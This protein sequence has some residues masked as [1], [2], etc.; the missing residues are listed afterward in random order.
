MNRARYA[1]LALAACCIIAL[2]FDLTRP[3]RVL[4]IGDSI[5]GQYAPAAAATLRNHG[6]EAIVRSY[7]GVGLLDEGPRIDAAVEVRHDIASA[8]ARVV[9]A[10]F[11][12]NYG[13]VDPPLPGVP[14]GSD[15]F[16]AAW[17]AE[18]AMLARQAT[19]AG[20]SLV[21]LLAPP[22][23]RGDTNVSTRLS[24]LY[25]A[26]QRGRVT[27][28]DPATAISLLDR[29]GGLYAPDGRH[30]S[31]SG[32]KVIAN[33]VTERVESHSRLGLRFDE[34]LHS[35]LVIALAVIAAVAL[36]AV[37]A[38]RTPGGQRRRRLRSLR[39]AAR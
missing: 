35:A 22:P 21:W 38:A 15:A 27:V 33:L 34:L 16:Y 12:G 30:L 3:P 28:L 19:S 8:G 14:L 20:A 23:I 6:F 11:S 5:T 39:P 37:L 4:L 10:E 2:L 17:Q 9:V 31:A 36:A 1:L 24:A 7:P 32:V 25:R 29:N 26:E 13:I 18:S